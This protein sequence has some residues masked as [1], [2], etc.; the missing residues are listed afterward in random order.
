MHELAGANLRGINH[1]DFYLM[2]HPNVVIGVRFRFR[3][4]SPLRHAGMTDSGK[5]INLTQRSGES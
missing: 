5:K 3:L 2:R 1:E 4:D